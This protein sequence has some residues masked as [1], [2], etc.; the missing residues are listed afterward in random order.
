MHLKPIQARNIA[1]CNSLRPP[2]VQ[3]IGIFLILLRCGPSF[4]VRLLTHIRTIEDKTVRCL[5]G[6][7]DS[8][9]WVEND[10]RGGAIEAPK[11]G[12]RCGSSALK[13]DCIVRHPSRIASWRR[14]T[15]DT[16][17]V[18]SSLA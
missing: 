11:N 7:W 2:R 16:D 14:I 3:R 10:S 15:P 13:T 17:A 9:C 5:P 1:Y 18:S 12:T 8:L 4:W 6:V